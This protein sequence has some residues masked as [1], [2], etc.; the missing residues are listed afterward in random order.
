MR[1]YIKKPKP[2]PIM[3]MV[4]RTPRSVDGGTWQEVTVAVDEG[5]IKVVERRPTDAPPA[6][7]PI[8]VPAMG[9][10]SLEAVDFL[11]EGARK[12]QEYGKKRHP[13][14]MPMREYQVWL[15]QMWLDY[16]EQKLKFLQGK[17]Q[18]G[19]GGLFQRE[20]PGIQDWSGVKP[21]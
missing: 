6:G 13:R 15:Q 21:K 10:M 14:Q 16:V 4:Q 1:F 8:Y 3:K 17:T 19:P 11:V 5:K 12:A 9:A 2:R 20:K 7:R 18:I